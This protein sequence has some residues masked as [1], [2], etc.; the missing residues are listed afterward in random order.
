VTI[1]LNGLGVTSPAPV[2]GAITPNPGTPLNLPIT[3]LDGNQSVA[4]AFAA[5]GS[6]SGVWQ[7]GIL[8]P[9]NETG[10]VPVGL[11]VSGV[12]LRDGNLT[13]WVK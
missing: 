5:P 10:A 11:S 2:T 1:F 8:M 9:T 4:F 7:V 12:P 6:I 13:I 3:L